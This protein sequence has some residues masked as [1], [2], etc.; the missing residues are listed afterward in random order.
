MDL[1]C[2]MNAERTSQT[3]RA[4]L[5][6]TFDHDFLSLRAK[7]LKRFNNKDQ[8][9]ARYK[10]HD[11]VVKCNFRL[12]DDFDRRDFMYQAWVHK[13]AYERMPRMT[14]RL[15]KAYVLKKGDK[16]TGVHIMDRLLGTTLEDFL[17]TSKFTRSD[18]VML[19]LAEQLKRMFELM[20]KSNIWHGDLNPSN[21]IVNVDR[22]GVVRN[23]SIIDFGG[24]VVDV[25]IKNNDN[26]IDFLTIDMPGALTQVF[27]PYFRRLGA[28]IPDDIE[29]WGSDE[30]EDNTPYACVQPKVVD[31]LKRD[32]EIDIE[33]VV[34]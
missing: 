25:P 23:V 2:S 28:A 8:Y 14:P 17:L 26:M 12:E 22:V 32:P 6:L 30:F 21:I 5:P 3:S 19:G 33:V 9:M 15:R 29:D 4:S 11:L 27:I 16:T 24:V 18:E 31:N 20:T 34:L 10:G 13:E 7:C 1:L